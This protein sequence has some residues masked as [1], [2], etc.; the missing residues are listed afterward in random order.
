MDLDAMDTRANRSRSSNRNKFRGSKGRTTT[1]KEDPETQ[2]KEGHCYSCNKQGH[3]ARNCPAKASSDK[4]KVKACSAATEADSSDE[5]PPSFETEGGIR[6]M[7][8]RGRALDEEK[9][10]SI[11]RMIAENENMEGDEQDF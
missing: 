8:K 4:G 1:T 2:C 10:L 3:I 11:T 9:K 5:E 6:S 7:I